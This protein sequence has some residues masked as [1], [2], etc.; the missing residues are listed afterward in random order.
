MQRLKAWWA[1]FYASFHDSTVIVFGRLQVFF[2]IVFLVL[3]S[4]DLS[5]LL[6]P[7]YLTLWLVFSGIITEALR[8]RSIS[9]ERG[10]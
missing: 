6:P 10:D 9:N 1:S 2:G 3:Q 5:P 7:K 8:R 4:V